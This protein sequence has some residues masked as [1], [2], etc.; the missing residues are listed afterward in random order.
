MEKTKASPHS[1]HSWKNHDREITYHS[2]RMDASSHT[3]VP[4]WQIDSV[5]DLTVS[6]DLTTVELKT[7]LSE[8]AEWVFCM[9][10]RKNTYSKTNS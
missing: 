4:T 1:G 3:T 9:T 6:L 2:S 5:Y 10:Y 7:V 8:G